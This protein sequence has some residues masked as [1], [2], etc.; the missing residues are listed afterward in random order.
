MKKDGVLWRTG[1]L[2]GDLK[3]VCRFFS[4]KVWEPAT[5]DV[6]WYK[7]INRINDSEYSLWEYFFWL[8]HYYKGPNS[9]DLIRYKNMICKDEFWKEF[10]E[11]KADADRFA[12]VQMEIHIDEARVSSRIRSKQDVLLDD[13]LEIGPV[14]RI[15]L[16]LG[17]DD[18][19]PVIQKFSCYAGDVLRGMPEFINHAPLLREYLEK[20]NAARQF[21]PC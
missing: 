20:P 4:G 15:E 12:R 8:I 3:Q 7:L 14:A 16:A 17:L 21:L 1:I 11:W 13:T 19:D 9:Q 6:I 10:V 5:I 2:A 18:P